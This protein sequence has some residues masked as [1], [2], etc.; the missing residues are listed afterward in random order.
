MDGQS[1]APNTPH[2]VISSR[3][4]KQELKIRIKSQPVTVIAEQGWASKPAGSKVDAG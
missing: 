2:Y 1:S 3:E 4:C